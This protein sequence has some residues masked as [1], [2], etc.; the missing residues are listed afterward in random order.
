MFAEMRRKDRALEQD[1]AEKLLTE[2]EYGILTVNGRNG[3]PHPV[4]MSYAFKDGVIWL[5]GARE[6]SKVDD[7]RV[8]ARVSFTVVGATEVLPEKFSTNYRSVICY[9]EAV[10]VTG[11]EAE[12]ALLA[13]IEKYSPGFESE[14]RAYI[15]RAAAITMV[16]RLDIRHMTGKAR[17]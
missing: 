16:L 3:Y 2:G 10:E 15:G 17:A 11:N 13:L 6:G 5:H 14:G 12:Q 4:P 8:D 1:E 7:I 9:G